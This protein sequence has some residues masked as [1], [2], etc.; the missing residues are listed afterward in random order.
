M[1]RWS[2]LR[3]GTRGGGLKQNLCARGHGHFLTGALKPNSAQTILGAELSE[4]V[5]YEGHLFRSV[6][7]GANHFIRCLVQLWVALPKRPPQPQE[8][9]VAQWPCFLIFSMCRQ[10]E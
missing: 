4:H 9:V 10:D 5:Q 1:C 2:W 6:R 3:S 7:E 8:D